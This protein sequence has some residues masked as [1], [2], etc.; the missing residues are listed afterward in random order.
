MPFSPVDSA[1]AVQSST[2]I[3]SDVPRVRNPDENAQRPTYEPLGLACDE[4]FAIPAHPHGAGLSQSSMA[5]EKT[6][7]VRS[8]ERA[9]TTST[10]LLV[11]AVR[12]RHTELTQ[13][14]AA[15]TDPAPSLWI[16]LPAVLF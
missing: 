4:L 11:P 6:R 8:C 7:G 12:R 1:V 15:P 10:H 2:S 14:N 5:L 9:R 16:D 3:N 13:A